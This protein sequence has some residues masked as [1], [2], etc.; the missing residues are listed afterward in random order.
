MNDIMFAYFNWWIITIWIL[1]WPYISYSFFVRYKTIW[2]RLLRLKKIWIPLLLA[3]F[4]IAWSHIFLQLAKYEH[5][6]TC[7]ITID[8]SYPLL[9][10]I[11]LSRHNC[12]PVCYPSL[13]GTGV[14]PGKPLILLY[15]QK[16]TEI[17]VKLRYA[18]GFSATFPAY[19]EQISGWSVVAHPDGTLHDMSSNQDTYGLFW[20]GNSS[21]MH[22]DMSRWF[23][24]P[25]SEIREFLYEKLT[26]LWLNTKERSD[27]IT[28][29]YPKLQNY[30]YIQITFAGKDY[31]D[32]A[33]LEI[34]PYHPDSLLRVFMVAKPQEYKKSIPPQ[35][36]QK[37]E[38]KGFSVVEW[39]G[40]IIE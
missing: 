7:I 3:I 35:D 30:P 9:S 15:P 2:F 12:P 32:R 27:F 24:V 34:T 8:Y 29:W 23:V 19:W 22:F 25:W 36:I 21:D 10:C 16:D 31:T 6:N 20:E 33:E 4:L 13:Y 17:S 1:I 28:F 26:E 18:P 5:K 40:T 39:W 14:S 11:P 38:R 37:F